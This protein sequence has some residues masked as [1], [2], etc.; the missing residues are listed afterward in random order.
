M[1]E[2]GKSYYL[3]RNIV[4]FRK[5][6]KLPSDGCAGYW[7]FFRIRQWQRTFGTM[8]LHRDTKNQTQTKLL[9]TVS[10]EHEVFLHSRF[11]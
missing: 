9:V 4:H 6:L 1:R 10:E 8:N 5:I 7:L 3:I 2:R 11:T